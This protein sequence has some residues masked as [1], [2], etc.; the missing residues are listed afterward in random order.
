M[1]LFFA[2]KVFK[3]EASNERC[4][5]DAA[6]API[7]TKKPIKIIRTAHHFIVIESLLR[8]SFTLLMAILTGIEV[9][10]GKL[11]VTVFIIIGSA[12]FVA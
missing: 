2:P 12:S 3:T 9:T 8:V 6:N 5:S 10:F 1:I 7:I 4:C 11:L